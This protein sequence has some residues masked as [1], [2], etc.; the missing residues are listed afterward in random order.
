MSENSSRCFPNVFVRRNQ[1]YIAIKSTTQ[2]VHCWRPC[3]LEDNRLP[4]YH[5]SLRAANQLGNG[6]L[7]HNIDCNC[8]SYH[9]NT[10]FVSHSFLCITTH[11]FVK[12]NSCKSRSY[13]T[14]N[15][16]TSLLKR[17]QHTCLYITTLI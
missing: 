14:N 4:P 9:T 6:L 16:R 11:N 8:R 3:C 7:N 15:V 12:S 17:I 5:D 1:K 13:Y 10:V 2:N